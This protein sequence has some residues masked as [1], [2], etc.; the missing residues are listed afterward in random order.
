M[1]QIFILFELALKLF[2]TERTMM[3]TGLHGFLHVTMMLA[4]P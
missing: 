2:D 1:T 3:G 4:M